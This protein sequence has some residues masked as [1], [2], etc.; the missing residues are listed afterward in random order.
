MSVISAVEPIAGRIKTFIYRQILTVL[1]LLCSS[2]MLYGQSADKLGKFIPRGYTILDSISGDLNNDKRPD[3]I[4]ILQYDGSSDRPFLLL[5]RDQQ[6]HL[7]LAARNNFLIFPADLGG[8]V[9]DPYVKTTIDGSCFTV[10]HFYGSHDSVHQWLTFCYQPAIQDW[11]LQQEVTTTAAANNPD[12]AKTVVKKGKQL[13]YTTI[14]TY[15][16]GE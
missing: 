13:G 7:Q 12:A 4:L 6:Q 5:I 16:G 10:E 15:Q 8:T 9:G 11:V 14:K 1:L 3:L 2:I